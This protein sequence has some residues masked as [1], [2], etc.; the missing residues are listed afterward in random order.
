MFVHIV[1]VCVCVYVC[2]RVCVRACVYV[3]VLSLCFAVGLSALSGFCEYLAEEKRA[4]CYS[5]LCYCCRVAASVVSLPC[6][7]MFF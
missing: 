2:V 4:D 1:C 7:T 6:G 3:R 5:S